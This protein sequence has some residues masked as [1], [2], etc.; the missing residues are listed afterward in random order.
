M[1]C[2]PDDAVAEFVRAFRARGVLSQVLPFRSGFHTPMLAPYLD[3]IEQAARRF[4][5]QPP[6][7][8]VWSA[9]TAAP[10]PAGESAVRELFVRHLLEP[11]RFR[12]LIEAMYTA[13]HRAFVQVG[14]GQLGSLI[15]DTLAGATTWSSP[16]TPPTATASPSS[17]AWQRRC[18]CRG[19]PLHRHCRVPLPVAPH[20]APLVPLRGSGNRLV[21]GVVCRWCRAPVQGPSSTTP[22]PTLPVPPTAPRNRPVRRP[23]CGGTG[24]PTVRPSGSTW[25][26]PS[27]PSTNRR[28]RDC[29]RS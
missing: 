23:P 1:V 2:G 12:Q 6:T 9:T 27:Y 19:G 14:T 5:L 15:G 20:T 3:P 18:G 21:L 4:R 26:A 11:V 13:G 8:P 24:C 29:A 7:V 16:P 25:A 10:F 17:A 28:S 22:P